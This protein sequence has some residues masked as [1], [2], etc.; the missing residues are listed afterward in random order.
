LGLGVKDVMGLNTF[1]RGCGTQLPL[2]GA[3][4]L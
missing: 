3:I 4:T 1:K 2:E